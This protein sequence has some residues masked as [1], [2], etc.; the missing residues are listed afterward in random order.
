MLAVKPCQKLP[1]YHRF[2]MRELMPWTKSSCVIKKQS[3]EGVQ[4][5]RKV[6]LFTAR[7]T[8]RWRITLLKVMLQAVVQRH[9]FHLR[10]A[11]LVHSVHLYFLVLSREKNCQDHLY[12]YFTGAIPKSVQRI[13][14]QDNGPE[15]FSTLL[16]IK[17]I[18][19]CICTLSEAHN[20]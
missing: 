5:P 16:S 14:S 8:T 3:L 10:G 19:L 20:G 2:T 15:V 18:L 1:L 7:G 9:H 11:K 13:A 4:G 17:I 6:G 12:S